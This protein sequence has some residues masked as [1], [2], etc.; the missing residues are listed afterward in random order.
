MVLTN[1]TMPLTFYVMSIHYKLN[2]IH[3]ILL[4]GGTM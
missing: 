4:V 1:N 2:Y 3:Y